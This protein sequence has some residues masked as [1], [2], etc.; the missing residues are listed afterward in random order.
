MFPMLY[1]VKQIF[2][3]SFE[4]DPSGAVRREIGRHDLSGRYTAGQS[5]AVAVGSRGIQGIKDMVEA[6][7][8]SLKEMGLKP[9]IVPAMGSHRPEGRSR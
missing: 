2:D 3:D 7:L 1:R 5:V 4:P 9:F 8:S 6:M